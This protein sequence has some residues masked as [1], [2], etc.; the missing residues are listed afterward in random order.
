MNV[1]NSGIRKAAVLVASLDQ[2]AADTVLEQMSPEQ[3]AR[4]RQAMVDLGDIDPLEQQ[5]VLDEFF[6]V[7][8]AKS[9]KHL[10]GVEVDAGLAHKLAFSQRPVHEKAA[11]PRDDGPPFRFLIQAE[12]DK[13]ARVLGTERPQ[14]IALVLSHLSAEQAGGVLSR[15]QPAQQ[16]EV[17]RRLVDLEEA[18]PDILREVERG[19]QA[20]LSQQV[21]MQRRRVAGISAVA[22]ILEAADGRMAARILDNLTAY[23]QPLAEKLGPPPL[24][25]D[26]LEQLDD[27]GLTTVFRAAE[28]MLATLALIGAPETLIERIL[29]PLSPA[30][31]Q[32]A[33]QR[34][35]HPGPI[36]LSDVESA[37]QQVAALARRLLM[38]RRIQGPAL[39]TC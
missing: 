8:P 15:L 29:A 13:L 25:F 9:Q 10:P 24:T 17:V 34:L 21:R 27:R 22:G 23:D 2:T 28:P 26:D 1:T 14:T 18:D 35:N 4:V 6:H 39:A 20:R 5:R 19:L 32:A 30:D 16:V 3:A 37:R 33:R 36:R 7:G 12:A 31:A 11:A 38:E